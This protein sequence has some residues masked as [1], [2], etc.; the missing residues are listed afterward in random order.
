MEE[1]VTTVEVLNISLETAGTGKELV[2]KE[3]LS[4]G[5]IRTMEKVI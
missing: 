1:T 4:M 5:E 3:G 2:R